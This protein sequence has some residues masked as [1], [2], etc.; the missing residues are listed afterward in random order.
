MQAV[1]EALP[2]DVLAGLISQFLADGLPPAKAKAYKPYKGNNY[3]FG[4]D[5]LTLL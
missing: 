1:I 3:D 2:A 5:W 4:S